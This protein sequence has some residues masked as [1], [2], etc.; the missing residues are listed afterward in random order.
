LQA[1]RIPA[2]RIPFFTLCNNQQ[3]KLATAL[4]QAERWRALQV[5][6]VNRT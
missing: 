2:S 3:A 1:S 6:Q 5:S 4:P